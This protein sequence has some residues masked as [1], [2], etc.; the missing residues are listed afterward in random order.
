MPANKTK[1]YSNSCVNFS[2]FLIL[3]N[4]P[5]H[6]IPFETEL[7][8]WSGVVLSPNWDLHQC[9]STAESIGEK[10][11]KLTS[12]TNDKSYFDAF[13]SFLVVIY[14]PLEYSTGRL[15]EAKI[16][17]ASV[18]LQRWTVH[19]RL[20]QFCQRLPKDYTNKITREISQGTWN[21]F[22]LNSHCDKQSAMQT[23]LAHISF[24]IYSSSIV[25]CYNI[26]LWLVKFVI[27]V[28]ING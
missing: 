22:V 24:A 18:S 19:T 10:A 25:R 17:F 6:V 4:M 16:T 11:F 28:F 21:S 12:I 1:V 23:N 9:T 13:R 3:S 5:A 2:D 27:A 15:A 26:P 8:F 7:C 20:A 14:V